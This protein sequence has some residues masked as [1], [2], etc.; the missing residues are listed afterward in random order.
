MLAPVF[1]DKTLPLAC[2][3]LAAAGMVCLLQAC[4]NL[5][6]N[7]HRTVT[8]ALPPDPASPLVQLA[9]EQKRA[10]NSAHDNAFVVLDTADSAYASRLA[11]IENAR[12]SLD[13]QYYA[14]Q[15]DPS[16]RTLM[17]AIRRAAQRGVR[18]RMLVDDIHVKGQNLR[19]LRMAYANNVEMRL[20][21]PLPGGRSLGGLRGA[22][23][24][25]DF[26]RLQRRMHNKVFLADNVAGIV[27]GRNLGEAY[28]GQSHSSNFAD[29][30]VLVLGSMARDMSASF[31]QYWNHALAFPVERLVSRQELRQMREAQASAQQ[32]ESSGTPA[33]PDPAAPD[34]LPPAMALED[35]PWIYAPGE[36]WADAPDKLDPKRTPSPTTDSV[37]NR[38]LALLQTAHKEVWIVSPYLVPDQSVMDVLAGLRQ[39]GVRVRILT[40]SL[41]SNDVALAHIG[42]ARW[43]KKIL[44][45]GVEVHE[46]RAE[47]RRS[48]RNSFTSSGK[49]RRASLHAKVFIVDHTLLGIGSMNL[50]PRSTHSN[51]EVAVVIQ[52][53]ALAQAMA[54]RL[55]Q[56]LHTGAW[57]VMLEDNKLR[58]YAPDGT[59]LPASQYEPNASV[60]VHLLIKVLA[61]FISDDL[62]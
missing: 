38:L 62:L 59:P 19:V 5:P 37:V 40:N 56:V 57:R 27:G 51:S 4:T 34:D 47:Q 28:F 10:A 18:V 46:M 60:P 45:L 3:V 44:A 29:M 7:T 35:A 55:E 48:L 6:P 22:L 31:D 25:Q 9:Q 20:F 50:D 52:S 21:N 39:R 36:F 23:V 26:D 16:T 42:Y 17:R 11:L 41:A 33:Q 30:D 13:V 1:S 15:S 58:W 2:R 53:P 54:D 14:I 8:Q 24:L 49:A 61:P 32:P 43:R 12:R